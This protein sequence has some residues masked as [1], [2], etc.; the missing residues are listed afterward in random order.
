MGCLEGWEGRGGKEGEEREE[1]EVVVWEGEEEIFFCGEE[2]EGGLTGCVEGEP[3]DR[4]ITGLGSWRRGAV[5]FGR[6]DFF[7]FHQFKSKKLTF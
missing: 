4:R 1:E 3:T 5:L 6:S 2:E 7:F